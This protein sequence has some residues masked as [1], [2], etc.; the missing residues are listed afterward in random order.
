[1]R[2]AYGASVSRQTRRVPRKNSTL[3]TP[4][5]AMGLTV[6][7][8]PPRRITR[9]FSGSSTDGG[10]RG[11][12]A[13]LTVSCPVPV[14]VWPSESSAVAATSRGPQGAFAGMVNAVS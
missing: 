12:P 8:S 9:R 4:C 11:G 7:V 1:M 13:Q 5:S 10:V 2:Q 3:S 14:A 6:T